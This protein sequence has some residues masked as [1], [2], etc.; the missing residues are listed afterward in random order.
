MLCT[1]IK[2]SKTHGP[3]ISEKTKVSTTIPIKFIA[4][5]WVLKNI[6][7]SMLSNVNPDI[8]YSF[9]HCPA[10]CVCFE[11]CINQCIIFFMWWLVMS[12]RHPL[13][14]VTISNT[15]STKYTHSCYFWSHTHKVDC[16][17]K[18]SIK[19]K[20]C[21]QLT[22]NKK[23]K[24][25]YPFLFTNFHKASFSFLLCLCQSCS[26]TEGGRWH[27]SLFNGSEYF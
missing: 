23:L 16:L 9:L 10:K 13:V 18:C 27:R 2:L 25:F 8:K 1:W 15:K 3:E 12:Q 4:Q 26:C 14:G 17:R 20:R 21:L 6:C 22:E 24:I 19:K 7:L 11:A 5:I